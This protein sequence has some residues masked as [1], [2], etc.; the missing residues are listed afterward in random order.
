[1]NES[2]GAIDWMHRHVGTAQQLMVAAHVPH[3]APRAAARVRSSRSGH[4]SPSRSWA[5]S[6]GQAITA[7][8]GPPPGDVAGRLGVAGVAFEVLADALGVPVELDGAAL[9]GERAALATRTFTPVPGRTLRGHGRMIRSGTG[10]LAIN[11]PRPED[12]ATL[13]ALTLGAVEEGDV[14]GFEAW[15][16]TVSGDEVVEQGRLLGLALAQIPVPGGALPEEFRAREPD[17]WTGT[18]LGP[19]RQRTGRAFRVVDFSG[20][21][22]GPLCTSLL[23]QLGADVVRVTGRA[24]PQT[25][26]PYDEAFNA[27]VS[28]GVRHLPEELRDPDAVRNLVA[29]ADLIVTSSRPAGLERLGLT[30]QQGRSWIRITA[31]GA[32]PVSEDRVG[33]GD[34]AA[35]SVGAVIDTPS[36]PGFAADALADPI[37]GLL[38]AVAGASL[39]LSGQSA[40]V[41]LSLAGSAAWAMGPRRE[42]DAS[43]WP[44]SAPRARAVGSE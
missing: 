11:L 39:M 24:R 4:W 31:H 38:A 42:I 9:L 7:S 20:L 27:L 35:A 1:M 37:T 18:C 26:A 43:R 21:W 3:L 32:D 14:E 5:A 8:D 13:P 16:Q 6:G 19:A 2:L 17:P 29:D 41:D 44:S 12:L 40:L 30:A 34:D 10:W 25:P 36:G 23:A 33:F 15:A 22:A 28:R